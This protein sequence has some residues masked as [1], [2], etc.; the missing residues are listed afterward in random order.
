MRVEYYRLEKSL[1][2]SIKKRSAMNYM[3]LASTVS[4]CLAHRHQ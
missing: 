1:I 4:A 2:S 3:C